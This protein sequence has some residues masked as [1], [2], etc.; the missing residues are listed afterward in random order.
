MGELDAKLTRANAVF[1]RVSSIP[2]P[3][4]KRAKKPKNIKLENVTIDGNEGNWEDF[5]KFENAGSGEEG[6]SSS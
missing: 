3:K 2:K 6:A 5:V 1:T 4:E